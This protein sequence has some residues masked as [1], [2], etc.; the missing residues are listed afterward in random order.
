MIIDAD[1][2]GS[3]EVYTIQVEYNW[4]ER[5]RAP[6]LVSCLARF[7]LYG[8]HGPIYRKYAIAPI[9]AACPQNYRKHAHAVHGYE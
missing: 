1:Y 2:T 5:E 8:V 9:S 4:G 7:C 6:P 3:K